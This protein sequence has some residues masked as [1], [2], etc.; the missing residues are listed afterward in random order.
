MTAAELEQL[1]KRP[2]KSYSVI[3]ARQMLQQQNA[4]A[5]GSQTPHKRHVRNRVPSSSPRPGDETPSSPNLP[6]ELAPANWRRFLSSKPP[7][8]VVEF[9]HALLR[10]N[11]A[12]RALA[13]RVLKKDL[14]SAFRCIS[15]SCLHRMAKQEDLE[16]IHDLIVEAVADQ[17]KR[18]NTRRAARQFAPIFRRTPGMPTFLLTWNPKR[19][20]WDEAKY[21]D[22]I[23]RTRNGERVRGVWSCGNNRSIERGDRLFLLRQGQER[24]ILAAGFAESDVYED[25]HWDES[26]QD[27]NAHYVEWRREVLLPVQERLT[28]EEL[29]RAHLDIDWDNLQAS[30]VRVPP[31]SVDRLEGLWDE[32][33]ASVG[34]SGPIDFRGPE[35][36]TKP[37]LY[38][39]G[40]LRRIAV[41]SYERNPEAR[42]AC[43]EHYGAKC[44]VCGFDF[45]DVYGDIGQGYIHVHHLRDLATIKKE[46][47][48][49]PVEDMRPVCPNCHAMLHQTTPAMVLE[50]L[51]RIVRARKGTRTRGRGGKRA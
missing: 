14:R 41:D 51:Q 20:T 44:M 30:G 4:P 13:L 37:Q 17:E 27:E 38:T 22:E 31:K 42:R 39:E 24:G 9:A 50:K 18:R 47:K 15:L 8:A 43:I 36:V 7:A 33:L 16:I 48:V 12:D 25:V 11:S 45:A 19:W 28:I 34:W 46:Y 26:R 49:D 32:H 29:K 2:G 40:A 35:E 21:L 5:A 23:R 6:A 1:A 10:C 3:L